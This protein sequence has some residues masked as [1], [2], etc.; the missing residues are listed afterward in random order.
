MP[1]GRF[2]KAST[3]YATACAAECQQDARCHAWPHQRSG[4]QGPAS[5]CQLKRA[6]PPIAVATYTNS[7]GVRPIDAAPPMESRE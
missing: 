6:V 2:L 7:G 4:V 3:Q 1:G 5:R